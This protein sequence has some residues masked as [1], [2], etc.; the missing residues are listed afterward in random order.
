MRNTVECPGLFSNR[1]KKLCSQQFQLQESSF[2][3]MLL[4]ERVS[5]DL[6]IMFEGTAKAK[7]DFSYQEKFTQ[8]SLGLEEV[9]TP[10]NL[11]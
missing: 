9:K 10:L 6:L 4:T 11:K 1:Y 2:S 7:N 5:F 8:K 3:F